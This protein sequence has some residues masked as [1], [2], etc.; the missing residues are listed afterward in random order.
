MH[1][2]RGRKAIGYWLS[3][4]ERQPSIEEVRHRRNP[5]HEQHGL[6]WPGD[7]ID[8]QWNQRERDHVVAYLQQTLKSETMGGLG[9]S[10]CRLCREAAGPSD[11][12]ESR[13]E[14][15][16]RNGTQDFGDGVYVWP[17]GYAH[18]VK[19]HAV[20][21]PEEFLQHLHARNWKFP[22]QR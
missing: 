9:Y 13:M 21:P 22:P 11:P 20:K 18:Y 3:K 19:V 6:L 17:E 7:F 2:A 12:H 1:A 8:E 14:S 10:E 5:A 4:K 15:W 16:E